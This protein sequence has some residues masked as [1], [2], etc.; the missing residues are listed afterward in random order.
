MITEDQLTWHIDR[1]GKLKSER[2]NFETLWQDVVDYLMPWKAD[3]TRSQSAGAKKTDLIYDSTP[4]YALNVLSAGLMGHLTSQA[5]PWFNLTCH[6]PFLLG[7]QEVQVWLQEVSRRMMVAFNR[8]NFSTAIHEFYED[9]VGFG[10]ASVFSVE[11]PLNVIRFH[12]FP[13]NEIHIVENY[14]GQIDTVYREYKQSVRELAQEFGKENLGKEL[15][16]KLQQNPEIEVTCVHAVFPRENFLAELN[17]PSEFAWASIYWVTDTKHVLSE[18]GYQ[19]NPWHV[20]RWRKSSRE[21][22]GRGPGI[23]VM[24]DIKTLNQQRRS[25]LR[26]GQKMVEPPLWVPASFKGRLR[27]SPNAINYFKK[28]D[29]EA[30]AM[31][32]VGE[33][34]FGLELT[35]DTR[36]LIKTAFFVDVFLMLAEQGSDRMTAT[37]VMERVQERLMILGPVLGRFHSEAL[38]PLVERGFNIMARSGYFPPPPASLQ[39]QALDIEYISPLAK[40]QRITDAKSTQEALMFAGQ[41]LQLQATQ[42]EAV[43]VVDIDKGIRRGFEI[44]GAPMDLLRSPDQVK[45]VR[46]ARA[47]ALQAQ[48]MLATMQQGADIGKTL[49]EARA[50]MPAPGG[51]A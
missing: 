51:E 10:T 7:D 35:Q 49:A 29:E 2:S 3:I 34:P 45:A 13:I 42:S 27:T 47:K 23:D 50:A 22:Y 38:G 11:D 17:I 24:P 5:A 21:T 4:I 26:G 46:E 19:E 39:G 31:N 36:N 44:Y 14:A 18:S 37:E 40:A 6:N 20:A 48:Q 28:G 1:L 8:S 15:T 30:K 25:D 41:F 33:L 9:L 12:V 32:L 43:D 16:D